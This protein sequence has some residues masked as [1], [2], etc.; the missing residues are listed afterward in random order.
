MKC[1]LFPVWLCIRHLKVSCVFVISVLWSF[2]R[3]HFT[4][5]RTATSSAHCN[6]T[7]KPVIIGWSPCQLMR[8]VAIRS[9]EQNHRSPCSDSCTL[10]VSKHRPLI[11]QQLLITLP[12]NLFNQHCGSSH[13][14]L[15]ES[16]SVKCT[17]FPFTLCFVSLLAFV[18]FSAD[19]FDAVLKVQ[20]AVCFD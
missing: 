4:T 15:T 16:K 5:W 8:Q 9:K 12:I 13:R 18:W 20:C 17:W 19:V 3:N 6:Y 7:Y 1:R 2:S 11:N 10:S 14:A